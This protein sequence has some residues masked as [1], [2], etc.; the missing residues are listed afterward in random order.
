[1]I[2]LREGSTITAETCPHEADVV[3]ENRRPASCGGD[4]YA[5]LRTIDTVVIAATR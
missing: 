4:C 5:G 1:M 3:A 2:E